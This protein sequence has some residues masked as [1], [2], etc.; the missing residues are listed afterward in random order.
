MLTFSRGSSKG[1]SRADSRNKSTSMSSSSRMDA[2]AGVV[3]S[4]SSSLLNILL[5]RF[6]TGVVLDGMRS[7]GRA[8]AALTLGDTATAVVLS[9][10]PPDGPFGP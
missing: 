6:S 5:W 4:G 2:T 10:M 1:N 8:S 7:G 3:N 9:D